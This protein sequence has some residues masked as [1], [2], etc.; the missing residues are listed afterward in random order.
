MEMNED[1]YNEIDPKLTLLFQ[2]IL[3]PTITTVENIGTQ[4]NALNVHVQV[5][6][7]IM[8]GFPYTLTME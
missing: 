7:K 2:L 6:E 3:C 1:I 8:Q 4:Y 5:Q